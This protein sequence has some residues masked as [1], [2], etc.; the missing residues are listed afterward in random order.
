MK[1][2]NLQDLNCCGGGYS[3]IKPIARRSE[4]AK[5]SHCCQVCML[6]WDICGDSCGD[7][8]VQKDSSVKLFSFH[9][10]YCSVADVAKY[11]HSLHTNNILIMEDLCVARFSILIFPVSVSLQF[12]NFLYCNS[13]VVH[14]CCKST[15]YELMNS[16]Q[17]NTLKLI[18]FSMRMTIQL[19][20]LK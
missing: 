10:C 3:V 20:W 19:L 5:Q 2:S 15:V 16:K 11:L 4:V 13:L 12:W 9:F 14:H 7:H 6:S 18:S 1:R 8:L 17:N